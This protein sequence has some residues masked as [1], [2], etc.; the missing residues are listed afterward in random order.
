MKGQIFH[1]RD[2]II[3]TYRYDYLFPRWTFCG[4]SNMWFGIGRA[5]NDIVDLVDLLSVKGREC[6]LDF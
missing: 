2:D 6:F 3:A 5:V 1:E 4:H